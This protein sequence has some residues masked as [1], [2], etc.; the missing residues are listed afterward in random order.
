MSVQRDWNTCL[1]DK[2]NIAAAVGA[3]VSAAG[4]GIALVLAP[5]PTTITKW[6]A[7]GAIAAVI[8]G[9][10]WIISAILAYQ[11]CLRSQTNPDHDQI[12]RLQRQVDQ[13]RHT[14]DELRRLPGAH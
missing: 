5:D 10:L 9:I 6:A 2:F 12:Q 13:L 1:A 11:N 4:A 7:V 14:V 8:A 3:T